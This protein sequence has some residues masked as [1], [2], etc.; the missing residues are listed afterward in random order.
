MLPDPL[1]PDGLT[2]LAQA[3]RAMRTG[4]SSEKGQQMGSRWPIGCVALE[5][6]QRCNLYASTQIPSDYHVE[7]IDY[8]WTVN[9][10]APRQGGFLFPWIL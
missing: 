7:F 9:R 5:I 6:T 2:A 1:P 10:A 4:G 3:R 8:D